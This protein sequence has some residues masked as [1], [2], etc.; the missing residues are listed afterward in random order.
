MEGGST[1]IPAVSDLHQ[2][3]QLH[4]VSNDCMSE[5]VGGHSH[6]TDIRLKLSY[7]PGQLVSISVQVIAHSFV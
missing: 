1:A 4:L 5:R 6:P 7:S 3:S 2:A